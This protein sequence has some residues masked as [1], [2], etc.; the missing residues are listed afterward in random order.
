M[1]QQVLPIL[2]AHCGCPQAPSEGVLK[3]MHIFRRNDKAIGRES[4]QFSHTTAV[5]RVNQLLALDFYLG[6]ANT[7]SEE[8][9][10]VVPADSDLSERIRGRLAL[11]RT[12]TRPFEPMRAVWDHKI[13]T[14]SDKGAGN[15]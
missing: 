15:D 12:R 8:A 7:A 9:I 1:P 5:M 10:D 11:G 4:S 13:A 3:V 14:E 2:E 6:A